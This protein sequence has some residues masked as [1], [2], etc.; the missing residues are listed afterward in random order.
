MIGIAPPLGVDTGFR[1]LSAAAQLAAWAKSDGRGSAPLSVGFL[2]QNGAMRSPDACW[3][4]REWTSV[5]SAEQRRRFPPVCPE[6]VVELKSPAISL[7]RLKRKMVEW[8]DNGAELAWLIVPD[9]RT[10]YIYRPGAPVETVVGASRLAA[11]GPVQ[12]F[13]LDLTDIWPAA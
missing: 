1:S 4:S 5:L 9:T 11:E 2:L 8:L 6:F 13:E 12:G 7:P 10:V 3:V